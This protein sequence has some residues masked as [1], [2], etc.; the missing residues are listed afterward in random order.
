MSTFR[1]SYSL[2]FLLRAIFTSAFFIF[3]P[4][5]IGNAKDG[6]MDRNLIDMIESQIFVSYAS[7]PDFLNE[8]RTGHVSWDIT[9]IIKEIQSDFGDKES[10]IAALE[11]ENSFEINEYHRFDEDEAASDPEKARINR[12]HLDPTGSDRVRYFTHNYW[13]DFKTGLALQRVPT[14]SELEDMYLNSDGKLESLPLVFKLRLII[15]EKQGAESD[16]QIK[17]FLFWNHF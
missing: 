5:L 7:S 1:F 6:N 10:F 4:I 11:K 8:Y 13:R 2:P 15:S 9:P 3:F 12:D 17:A 14:A 16:A